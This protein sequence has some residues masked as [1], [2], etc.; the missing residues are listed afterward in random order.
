MQNRIL[1]LYKNTPSTR[2]TKIIKNMS[3]GIWWLCWT[4]VLHTSVGLISLTHA[5]MDSDYHTTTLCLLCSQEPP[6]S[7]HVLRTFHSPSEYISPTG[8]G[9]CFDVLLHNS[10]IRCAYWAKHS[11]WLNDEY[12]CDR[13]SS[14]RTQEVLALTISQG[15]DGIAFGKRVAL[16]NNVVVVKRPL[17]PLSPKI[18]NFRG[19]IINIWAAMD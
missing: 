16:T 2:A 15:G 19:P 8:F 13:L 6:K 18:R 4:V 14:E 5:S 1:F 17:P 7:Y 11:L 10:P 12:T 3:M 9:F